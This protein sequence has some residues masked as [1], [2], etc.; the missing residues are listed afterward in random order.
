MRRIYNKIEQI[1]GHK[2][3]LANGGVVKTVALKRGYST[4]NLLEKIKST[5]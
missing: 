5:E 4:T 2:A 3:V 1:A